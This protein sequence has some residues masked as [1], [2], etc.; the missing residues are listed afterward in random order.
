MKQLFKRQFWPLIGLFMADGLFF[1]LTNPATIAS[2]W[3]IIGFGLLALTLY[4]IWKGLLWAASWYGL[5]T[6]RHAKR[7][8]KLLS[9][10]TVGLLALQSIGELTLRDVLVLLPLASLLYVYLSYGRSQAI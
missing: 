2:F 3:L 6:R 10:L 9:G 4:H 1:G 8:A 5:P 7:L